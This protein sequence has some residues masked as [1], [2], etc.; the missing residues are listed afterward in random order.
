MKMNNKTNTLVVALVIFAIFAG[1]CSQNGRQST[2]P[3]NT[4]TNEVNGYSF[5]YPA[6]CTFG[7]MP[8]NC[9]EKPP[10]ERPPECLCFL[11]NQNPDQVFLQAFLGDVENLTLAGFSVSHYDSPVYN[12]PS[13][14]ELIPWIREEFAEMHDQI[15]SEPNMEL[16]GVKAVRI[17][18]P[19]SPMAS[20]YE[21]IYFILNGKLFKINLLDIDNTDNKKLYDLMLSSFQF[22]E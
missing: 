4:Y 12:P 9:K 18:T 10:E 2:R 20:S 8:V 16:D 6:E 7:Q 5:N 21:D 14:T 17:T 11:D 3:W 13:G 1:A 22:D 19:K 15:P